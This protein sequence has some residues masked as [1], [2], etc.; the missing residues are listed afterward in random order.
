M[1]QP[2]IASEN[3]QLGVRKDGMM[4]I[5]IEQSQIFDHHQILSSNDAGSLTQVIPNL[6]PANNYGV[7]AK[8]SSQEK[9]ITSFITSEDGDSGE[10]DDDDDDDLDEIQISQSP[11]QNNLFTKFDPLNPSQGN[12]HT[13]NGKDF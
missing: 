12:T 10:R 1:V 2:R 9:Q 3:D 6:A 7:V 8:M 13:I 5:G 11:D 4:D